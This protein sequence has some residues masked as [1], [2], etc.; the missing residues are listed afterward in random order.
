M[1]LSENEHYKHINERF[2]KIK[3]DYL[4]N[5]EY[6]KYI[7]QMNILLKQ[8]N[9]SPRT[10]NNPENEYLWT[11]IHLILGILEGKRDL[12]ILNIYNF[13]ENQNFN[14]HLEIIKKL[15]VYSEL[16]SDGN[17][18]ELKYSLTYRLM[19]MIEG[20][21]TIVEKNT[22]ITEL[23]RK[24]IKLFSD[25][26]YNVF[27]EFVK[28][29]YTET[30]RKLFKNYI[31]PENIIKRFYDKNYSFYV[32]KIFE[33]II[34]VFEIKKANQITLFY[35]KKEF[36]KKGLGTAL[37]K[38]SLKKMRKNITNNIIS[39]NSSIYA[40]KIF[41]K[42]GFIK[43]AK[44]QKNKGIKYLPMEYKKSANVI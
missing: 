15:L 26:V 6:Q 22:K 2:K 19:T 25:L 33:K 1:V 14:E 28:K 9:L 11:K 12:K 3:K 24:D 31:L 27:G 36:Q 8:I 43:T 32:L 4:D 10:L 23:K 5:I 44:L 42:M 20:A 21:F 38:Y 29:D 40:G 41:L 37:F 34:G 17:N 18:E 7:E 30:A 13:N 35:V 16:N 39:V